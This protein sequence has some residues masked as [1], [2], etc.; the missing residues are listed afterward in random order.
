M[1]WADKETN[2]LLREMELKVS[3]EYKKASKKAQERLDDHL[4]RYRVKDQTWRRWVAEG[5][6]TEAEYREWRVGQLAI[7]KRWEA[8]KDRLAYEYVHADRIAYSIINGYMPEVYAVN[9]N[10]A[11]YQVESGLAVDTSYTLYNAEA[12]ERIM[13]EDP[14]LLPPPGSRV[15]EEIAQ[16]RA[17]RW[18]KQKIQS[19]MTQGIL[20]G[21]SIPDIAT[22]LAKA[23]GDA[24]RKAAIRNARTMT[25]GAQNAGRRDAFKRCK[26]L[27]INVRQQWIAT[28]DSRTRHSHRQLDGEVVNVG[29]KFSNGCRFPGDPDGPPSEIYNCRCTVIASLKGFEIDVT[30]TSLR[31]DKNLEGMSYED[32][33]NSHVVTSNLIDAPEQRAQ[34]FRWSYLNEYMGR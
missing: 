30:D 9:H 33:K 4:S 10:W 19:C 15:S 6:K 7:G 23:V 27:G 12:V 13:R 24:D 2:R 11:T 17:T 31:H 28:L 20:L 18:N 16:G 3:R 1:D 29:E 14:D 26:N 8:L 34:A 22:N 21:E 25:T 5:Q 32:W